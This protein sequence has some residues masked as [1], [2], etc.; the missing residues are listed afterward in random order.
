MHL[1]DKIKSA[2]SGGKKGKR[3]KVPRWRPETAYMLGDKVRYHGK[4]YSAVIAHTSTVALT[5]A[6]D[7]ASWQLDETTHGAQ[8]THGAGHVDGET[9][10]TCSSSDL[11]GDDAHVHGPNHHTSHHHHQGT[12]V[13]PTPA[14]PT[15]G[16]SSNPAYPD[17]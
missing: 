11:G 2:F 12:P 17:Y 15:T 7:S 16:S 6:L 10:S 4:V 13:V 9:S 5:P 3:T 1:I 8:H 14:G